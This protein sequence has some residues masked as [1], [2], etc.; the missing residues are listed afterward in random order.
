MNLNIKNIDITKADCGLKH[1]YTP[2]VK[3]NLDCDEESRVTVECEYFKSGER[4]KYTL[5]NSDSSASIDF[6]KVF[7]DKV[8]KING[9]AINGVPVT[10]EKLIKAPAVPEL[11][12]LVMDVAV[13]ILSSDTLT[14][15]E[16]KN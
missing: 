16:E 7:K 8:L 11:E 15:D 2:Q 4:M 12:A 1:T 3:W 6:G 9:L 13:H 14:K 10:P 5:L